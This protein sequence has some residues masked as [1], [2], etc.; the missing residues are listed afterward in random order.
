MSYTFS[1]E[2][3]NSKE[4]EK[5]LNSLLKTI[6]SEHFKSKVYISRHQEEHGYPVDFIYG[7][8]IS[9]STLDSVENLFF[10][11]VLSEISNK[12]NTSFYY[13][14]EEITNHTIRWN[15]KHYFNM[16][17]AMKVWYIVFGR[18]EEKRL[19]NLKSIYEENNV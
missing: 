3:P 2:L 9:F 17:I 15:L 8:Y 4:Q 10:H 14:D 13:D 7:I 11:N 18:I 12:F 16:G 5:L 19:I 6:N 1:L